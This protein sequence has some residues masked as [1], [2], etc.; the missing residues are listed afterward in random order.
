VNS[1]QFADLLF[2][3]AWPFVNSCQWVN[4]S[5]LCAGPID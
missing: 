1:V 5:S 2:V 3:Y 4:M